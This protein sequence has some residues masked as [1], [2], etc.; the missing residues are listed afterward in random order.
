M[1][2]VLNYA[3]GCMEFRVRDD[4][5]VENWI[6]DWKS[7]EFVKSEY[8]LD[9]KFATTDEVWAFLRKTLEDS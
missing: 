2:F 3:G 8:S 1:E 4:N 7:G 9:V 6:W 5:T